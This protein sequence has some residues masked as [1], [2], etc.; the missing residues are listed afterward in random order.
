MDIDDSKQAKIKDIAEQYQ[1]SRNHLM[2]VVHKLA[3]LG[4]IKSTQGRGGG[5]SLAEPASTI[6]VGDIIRA[7][8]PSLDIIDCGKTSC[9]FTPACLL[10]GAL[11][12]A[13][14]HFL[15]TL[16]EYSI[17][18]LVRNKPQLLSLINA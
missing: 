18:D 8:E 12:K 11:N 4:Y 1:V 10:K 9:P 16:D 15:E 2:K 5:I 14:N 7:M 3:Q 17:E 6:I 13:T